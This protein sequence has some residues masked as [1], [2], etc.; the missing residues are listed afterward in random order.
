VDDQ[1][2][3]RLFGAARAYFHIQDDIFNLAKDQARRQYRETMDLLELESTP[4][5]WAKVLEAVVQDW[6]TT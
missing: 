6:P 2:F 1:R 4:E 3:E 5:Q